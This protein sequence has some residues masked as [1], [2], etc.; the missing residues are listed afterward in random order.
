MGCIFTDSTSGTTTLIFNS[1]R[2]VVGGVGNSDLYAATL[3]SD[4]TFSSVSPISELNTDFLEQHPTCSRDGLEMYFVS[5][6]PGSIIHPLEPACGPAGAPSLDLWISTRASTSEP[7]RPA[8]NLDF[9]NADIGGGPINNQCHDGRPS[10]SSDGTELYFY[11]AFR[12]TGQPGGNLSDYFD[13]WVSTRPDTTAPQPPTAHISPA[14]NAAGWN[15]TDAIVSF[16]SNGDPGHISTGV[17]ECTSD[18]AI[19]SE[20]SGAMVDGT[21]TDHAGN[22]SAP[23]AVNVKLDK[24]APA[25]QVIGVRN[26]ETYLL[27]NVPGA[28]CNSSDGLSGL[29]AAATLT[30]SGGNAYGVGA[31]AAACSGA[32]DIAGNSA[33]SLTA[34]Y[35]VAYAFSGFLPPVGPSNEFKLGSTI[36]LKW[37]LRDA[38]GNYINRLNAVQTLQLSYLGVCSGSTGNTVDLETTG[39][40]GLRYDASS[41]QFIF[42]WQ[43]KGLPSGCYRITL[44]LDDATIHPLTV[45]LI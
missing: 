40:T 42:N 4:G 33:P 19:V 30:L 34:N 35:T 31:F 23:M 29:L 39:A 22:V 37:Q 12:N 6:R 38:S 36:P 41:N 20:T 43:T 15:N 14:P 25:V 11:S 10:L 32:V 17:A 24:A 5:D 9:A 13:I 8:E 28:G 45:S 7:W 27:G 1:D 21:C 3:Q 18:V 16:T 26:G 2:R 44:S